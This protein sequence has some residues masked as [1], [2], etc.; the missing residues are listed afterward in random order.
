M[1]HRLVRQLMTAD[2]CGMLSAHVLCGQRRRCS[3]PKE[4]PLCG[5]DGRVCLEFVDVLRGEAIIRRLEQMAVPSQAE[6][7][8]GSKPMKA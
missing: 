5:D 4:A 8:V 6:A 1:S 7:G 3:W 2:S